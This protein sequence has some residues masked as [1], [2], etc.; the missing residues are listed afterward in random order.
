M[1]SRGDRGQASGRPGSPA[2]CSGS[3]SS[4]FALPEQTRASPSCPGKGALG[5]EGYRPLMAASLSWQ[6]WGESRERLPAKN[7]GMKAFMSP[8]CAVG[9]LRLWLRGGRGSK[10]LCLLVCPCQATWVSVPAP[11]TYP[12]C[13]DAFKVSGSPSAQPLRLSCVP[14]DFLNS[15]CTFLPSGATLVPLLLLPS[16]ALFKQ[17]FLPQGFCGCTQWGE[18]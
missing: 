13:A 17:Y 7:T 8:A 15:I 18:A 16:S 3:C 2:R 1:S 10:Q 9:S 12:R 5:G 4:L 6:S 11:C 14:P